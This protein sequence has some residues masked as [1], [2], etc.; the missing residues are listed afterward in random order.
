MRRKLRR[1]LF[2]YD[3]R[4]EFHSTE[5]LRHNQR[6]L[7]HLASLSL[8]LAKRSVLEVGA[9]IGDHSSF[10]IDRECTVCITE[11]R[12]RNLKLLHRR[13]PNQVVRHL[14]LERPDPTLKD[15]F[16]IV[17][18]Y[19]LLYHL[20]TP[21][22]AI[23]YLADHCSDLML[24]E[25]CVSFG[26]DEAI[27]LVAEDA[28]LM[29]QA[30]SGTGCRPTRSWVFKELQRHFERVYMPI[31]QP[32]HL[33]FPLIW[34]PALDGLARAVFIASRRPLDSELLVPSIPRQQIRQ[35]AV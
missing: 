26:D 33:E 11:A 18:C 17:Y 9:G 34:D 30:I 20:R 4:T 12:D 5:Y 2:G 25:T 16:D 29:S 27:N 1:M 3:P 24:L 35:G 32:W 31:T 7:E 14:D 15:A 10:F 8:P 13:F 19:G 28:N 22:E 23:G 6:R 21:G